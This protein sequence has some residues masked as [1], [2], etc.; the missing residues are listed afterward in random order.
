MQAGSHLHLLAIGLADLALVARHIVRD[1]AAGSSYS[2]CGT[3]SATR[4]IA[5]RALGVW[6]DQKEDD[7]RE[8]GREEGKARSRGNRR[9][10]VMRGTRVAHPPTSAGRISAGTLACVRVRG[11]RCACVHTDRLVDRPAPALHAPRRAHAPSPPLPRAA[12][13]LSG[14]AATPRPTTHTSSQGRVFRGRPV[15][16]HA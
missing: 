2:D 6:A 12:R 15:V 7:E 11:V 9:G 13:P 3:V 1:A 10:G 4:L 8:R 14:P 16:P 5:S